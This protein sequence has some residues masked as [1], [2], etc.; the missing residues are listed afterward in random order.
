MDCRT[1]TDCIPTLLTVA[2]DA[3]IGEYTPT[4]P[5]NLNPN[6]AGIGEMHTGS[7]IF[8]KGEALA[9]SSPP[10]TVLVPPL[11]LPLLL[12]LPPLLLLVPS[13]LLPVPPLLLLVPLLV[14]LAPLV[15]PPLVLPPLLYPFYAPRSS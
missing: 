8:T 1:L 10:E 15:L 3:G 7:G 14:P 6:A 12:S 5:P 2:A 11:P 9:S 13:L 4:L